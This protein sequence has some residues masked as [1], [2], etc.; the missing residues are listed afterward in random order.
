MLAKGGIALLLASHGKWLSL[1]CGFLSL[2][3]TFPLCLFCKF[4]IEEIQAL[5]DDKADNYYL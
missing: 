3:L 1:G 5:K 4:V 2:P